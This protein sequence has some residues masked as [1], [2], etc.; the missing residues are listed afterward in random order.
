MHC[1]H[2]M[3]RAA[4]HYLCWLLSTS[5]AAPSAH[6]KIVDKP[7]QQRCVGTHVAIGVGDIHTGVFAAAVAAGCKRAGQQAT[8][9]LKTGQQVRPGHTESAKVAGQRTTQTQDRTSR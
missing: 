5:T 8:P 9:A 6:L 2:C 3:H 1:M 7:Q 4:A